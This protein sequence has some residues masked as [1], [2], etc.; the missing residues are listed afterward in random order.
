MKSII[1]VLIYGLSLVLVLGIW[2]KIVV[3][4]AVERATTPPQIE[5]E[6]EI[7]E[8][9]KSPYAPEQPVPQPR[10]DWEQS[11]KTRN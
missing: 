8:S 3:D 4:I 11:W 2:G 9:E 7:Q 10:G 6:V 1:Q 5:A